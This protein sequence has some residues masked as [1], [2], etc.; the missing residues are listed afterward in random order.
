MLGRCTGES[1]TCGAP[2]RR[3]PQRA[4]IAELWDEMACDH[5]PG[6]QKF[7]LRRTEAQAFY[8]AIERLN[9]E[10]GGLCLVVARD[11]RLIV[12]TGRA[13]ALRRRQYHPGH[14]PM[15]EEVAFE[16]ARGTRGD[17]LPSAPPVIAFLDVLGVYAEFETNL[18]RKRVSCQAVHAG[19][20]AKH[21]VRRLREHCRRCSRRRRLC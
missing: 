20:R 8:G 17:W 7:G 5:V 14:E 16:R 2:G 13:A 19:R 6:F 10:R 3:L 12:N 4:E 9:I 1:L 18:R 15:V 11:C 21:G